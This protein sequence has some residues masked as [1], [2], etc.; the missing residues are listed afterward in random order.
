MAK[1]KLNPVVEQI[2]GGIGDLI[3]KRYEGEVIVV[4]KADMT[5]REWSEAQLAKREQFRQAALYGKLV[6]ADPVTKARY[7]E[8]AKAQG[9]P[10]FSLTVADFFNAPSVDEVDLSAYTGKVGDVIVIR[11]SDDFEVKDVSVVLTKGDG[12]PVESGVATETPV[13][14][15]RWVYTAT[16]EM[17]AGT[18]VRIAVTA[19][20]RPGHRAVKT[21]TK[22]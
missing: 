9:Q 2:R 10:V 22:N 13:R 14:S 1:V 11:A 21:E 12:S 15:G 5:D 6:M 16:V 3:F 18:P 20:D 8:A 7:V 17:A 19:I 4:R